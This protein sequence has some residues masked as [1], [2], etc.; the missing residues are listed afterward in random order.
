MTSPYDDPIRNPG[1]AP[2][3][4]RVTPTPQGMV[5]SPDLTDESQGARFAPP[6]EHEAYPAA[7][8]GGA[9]RA[10][11]PEEASYERYRAEDRSLGEIA[12]DLLNNATTLIRQEVELA[13]VEAKQS[14][15]RAGKG[16]GMMAG[17]GVAGLL[18]L[19]ALTLT[20]WWGL[21]VLIGSA[22]DPSLGWSG[23]I[24]TIIWLVIAG[25]LFAVGKGE[26]NKVRGLQQTQDT[27]KK[28]P[29]AATGNEEKNR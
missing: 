29:N 28:I 15:T 22:D 13:K 6:S 1:V 5:G 14:A 17:A 4:A 24:V 7:G 11:T 12:S 3:P 9:T 20:A 10:V 16:I 18:A 2:D 8:V 25:V 21:A 27:V 19:I 23:L 26:F